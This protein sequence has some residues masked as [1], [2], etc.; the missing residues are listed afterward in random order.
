MYIR[1]Y[2]GGAHLC[3][4]KWEKEFLSFC[5]YT[6]YRYNSYVKQVNYIFQQD[7]KAAI[8]KHTDVVHKNKD[9]NASIANLINKLVVYIYIRI[10]TRAKSIYT[11]HNKKRRHISGM[12]NVCAGFPELLQLN[13][14]T[15][16][17]SFFSIYIHCYSRSHSCTHTRVYNHIYIQ[18]WKYI[19]NQ[20]QKSLKQNV[21]VTREVYNNSCCALK[22]KKN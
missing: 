15:Y 5:I 3:V 10:F 7:A 1:K 9:Y 17:Y 13:S 6:F 2:I 11:A 19:F 20:Q 8:N 12:L 16:Y 22:Q 14:S 21:Y 18:S 4:D